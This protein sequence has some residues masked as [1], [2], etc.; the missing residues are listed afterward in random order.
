[1]QSINPRIDEINATIQ[2]LVIQQNKL[3]KEK[4]DIEESEFKL[5]PLNYND[6]ELWY[7]VKDAKS[8]VYT[9]TSITGN[10]IEDYDSLNMTEYSLSI[11]GITVVNV[12]LWWNQTLVRRGLLELVDRKESGE[13]WRGFTA[14][15]IVTTYKVVKND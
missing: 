5:T 9:R 8:A 15:T 12:S 4:R 11:N 13:D 7:L 1:M 6:S 10:N 2:D 3:L 14:R